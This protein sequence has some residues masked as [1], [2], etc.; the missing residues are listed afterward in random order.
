MRGYLLVLSMLIATLA[1]GA[2]SRYSAELPRGSVS[3]DVMQVMPSPR[4]AELAL[5]LQEAVKQNREWWLS[6]VA[7]AAPGQPVSW[8]EKLG[9][10]RE[11]YAEFLA[12]SA[13]VSLVKTGEGTI[14]LLRSSDGR[15]TIRAAAP[16]ADLD[17]IVIDT[18]ADRV[19]T[20]FGETTAKSEIKASDEQKA[21]GP[22]NG[23]QWELGIAGAA[24]GT[25]TQVRFALG[26]LVESGRGILYYHALEVTADGKRRGANRIVL[27]ELAGSSQGSTP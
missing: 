23:E 5:K 22:W 11:E 24:A 8:D 7:K 1:A 27:F 10:T 6:H 2:E 19:E 12:E 3:V 16:L 26:R 18:R 14:E 13:N 25:G 20:P 17:G 9:L 21:T 4:T 15:I